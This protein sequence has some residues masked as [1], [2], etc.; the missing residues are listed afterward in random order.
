MTLK[1]VISIE[2]PGTATFC[3]KSATW[4][5][6]CKH[7]NMPHTNKNKSLKPQYSFVK[8]LDNLLI[9]EMS[10]TLVMPDV[11]TGITRRL[12]MTSVDKDYIM[13]GVQPPFV[14]ALSLHE[15][16]TKT[17]IKHHNFRA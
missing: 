17:A 15:K 2:S 14:Q 3:R 13:L 5:L 12:L 1:S 16:C 6:R 4:N 7:I 11:I 8:E 10:L 9:T